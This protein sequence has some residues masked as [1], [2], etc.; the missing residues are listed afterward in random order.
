MASNSPSNRKAASSGCTLGRPNCLGLTPTELTD[1]L[2]R[3]DASGANASTRRQTRR[4]PYRHWPVP[5]VLFQPQGTRSAIAVVSRNL[6]RG[7]MSFLHGAYVH[8]ELPVLVLLKNQSGVDVQITGRVTRC[9]HVERHLHEVG[10]RFNDPVNVHDFLPV[11]LVGAQFSLEVTDP[12]MLRGKLLLVADYDIDRQL[13]MHMLEPTQMSPTPVASVMEAVTAAG[14]SAFDIVL[15]DF[16]LGTGTGLDLCGALRKSGCTAPVIIMSSDV[17][18]STRRLAREANCEA[19]LNKPF[20]RDLLFSALAEFLLLG[21]ASQSEAGGSRTTLPPDSPLMPLVQKF[22]AEVNEIVPMLEQLL[23][24][25]KPEDFVRAATRLAGTASALG[26]APLSRIAESA[27]RSVNSSSSLKESAE[28][29]NTFV[30]ACK[31]IEHKA[32]ERHGS[33]S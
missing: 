16:D 32:A 5:V 25:D 21:P 33:R 10:V 3:L 30:A 26:F 13:I 6:S 23:R 2:D 9:R 24:D 22:A 19:F 28:A 4:L 7:G 18:G 20:T 31:R 11:D 12:G 8:T 1:V 14:K 29:V 27:I 17:S 15:S